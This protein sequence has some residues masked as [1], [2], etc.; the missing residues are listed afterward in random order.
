MGRAAADGVEASWAQVGGG[1]AGPEGVGCGGPRVGGW[2]RHRPDG[3]GV[4]A[5]RRPGRRPKHRRRWG[6]PWTPTG[7]RQRW[8][9][10]AGEVTRR[11][12]QLEAKGGGG[13]G[14]DQGGGGGGMCVRR[15]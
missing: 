11:R 1:Q 6:W 14:L 10:V 2:P 13:D 15:G 5:K 8:T 7:R 12:Q 3:G 9:A 4:G